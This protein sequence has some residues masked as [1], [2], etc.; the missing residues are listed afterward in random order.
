MGRLRR[1]ADR[2][3][4]LVLVAER[5]LILSFATATTGFR[6]FWPPRFFRGFG[7][8]TAGLT[9][10]RIITVTQMGSE[11]WCANREG[12]GAFVA[13]GRLLPTGATPRLCLVPTLYG[14]AVS[15][16]PDLGRSRGVLGLADSPAAMAR[17]ADGLRG[18]FRCLLARGSRGGLLGL[19]D[20][21]FGSIL[22][23][24]F[25]G[26]RAGQRARRR[27]PRPGSP[28]GRPF[29]RG[30]PWR[31]VAFRL[32]GEESAVL[33]DGY[34]AYRQQQQYQGC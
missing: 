12:L 18:G 21:G 4:V 3:G 19:H 33:G 28:E 32:A 5:D 30:R 2:E 10:P 34:A 13:E 16:V 22:A 29:L 15:V 24:F 20:R 27:V 31:V 6:G 8:R 1:E 25:L 9:G 23:I 7:S 14:L 26:R 11:S 17:I